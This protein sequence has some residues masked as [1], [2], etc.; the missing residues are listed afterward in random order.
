[1]STDSYACPVCLNN[2]KN[3]PVLLECGHCF[4]DSCVEPLY[5]SNKRIV[6][7]LCSK[8]STKVC[9]FDKSKVIKNDM[10]KID[11][12][13]RKMMLQD[14]SIDEMNQKTRH[15]FVRDLD[16]NVR[17][18]ELYRIFRAFGF[19]ESIH[20]RL[21]NKGKKIAFVH[22][23]RPKSASRAMK[24]L[25]GSDILGSPIFLE[26]VKQNQLAFKTS[27]RIMIDNLPE[28][29]DTNKLHN[30]LQRY[31]RLD[32][33]RSIERHQFVAQF[34]NSDDC[35]RFVNEMNDKLMFDQHLWIKFIERNE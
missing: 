23:S 14:V 31:G 27:S 4:C 8:L 11:E 1:M 12:K 20:T 2:I 5:S 9:E 21:N 10:K 7:P 26:P 15:L 32:Y 30:E 17:L 35:T 29:I 33:V 13:I 28:T 24:C 16:Y 25:Q 6:C 19:V 18:D 3:T 34:C 22:L